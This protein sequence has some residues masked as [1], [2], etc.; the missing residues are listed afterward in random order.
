[1]YGVPKIDL[2]E[3]FG[4]HGLALRT[5]DWATWTLEAEQT[6]RD[7]SIYMCI[8]Q[9]EELNQLESSMDKRWIGRT[10]RDIVSYCVAGRRLGA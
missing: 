4:V 1:L 5:L 8:V 7:S 10:L 3:T 2:N 6:Y 9:L